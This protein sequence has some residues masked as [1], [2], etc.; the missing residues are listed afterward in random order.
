MPRV[1]GT[2]IDE[3][4]TLTGTLTGTWAGGEAVLAGLRRTNG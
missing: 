1:V 2:P 3:D 4:Q